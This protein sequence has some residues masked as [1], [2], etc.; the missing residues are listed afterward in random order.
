MPPTNSRELHTSE[1][2]N[3]LFFV[4]AFGT[5]EFANAC[6][7]KHNQRPTG[8]TQLTQATKRYSGHIFRN[9]SARVESCAML[10]LAIKTT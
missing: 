10:L 3:R 5:A 9:Y 8:S 7:H 2:S 4:Y 6:I 1:T